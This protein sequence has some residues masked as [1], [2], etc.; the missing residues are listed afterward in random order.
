MF[1]LNP[2]PLQARYLV[3]GTCYIPY[4]YEL[5]YTSNRYTHVLY[6]A[7]VLLRIALG[8]VEPDDHAQ[9]SVLSTRRNPDLSMP[10]LL[11]R[12]TQAP[13]S[14]NYDM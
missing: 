7:C 6:L 1:R 12:E 14:Q 4:S 3:P 11:P 10:I 9:P 13:F 8:W 2:L 5:V